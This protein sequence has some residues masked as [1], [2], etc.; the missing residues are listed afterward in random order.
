MSSWQPAVAAYIQLRRSVGFQLRTAGVAL[1]RFAAFL[2]ARGAAHLTRALA[3]EWAQ[4]AP[5]RH[6]ATQAQRLSYVRGFARYWSAQDPDTEVPPCGLLPHRPHRAQP[7]LYSVAEVRRLLRAARQLPP[8]G[9]LRGATYSCL[10]GLLAVTGMRLGELRTLTYAAL[11]ERIH[12]AAAALV[13][14]GLRPGDRV[15]VF[16]ENSPDWPLSA[17]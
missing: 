16:C 11:V 15:V 10:L 6:P 13:A 3:L 5:P 4:A 1:A 8:V 2:D 17:S 7:Y 12:A 9:G 14:A